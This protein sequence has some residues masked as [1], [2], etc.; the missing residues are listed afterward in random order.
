MHLKL[1]E[2]ERKEIEKTIQGGREA[3][4]LKDGQG[5]N[6][7]L[8]V[9]ESR[10]HWIDGAS[11]GWLKCIGRKERTNCPSMEQMKRV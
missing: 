2:G 3:S 7:K 5:T 9:I 6:V 8:A 1:A 4:D 11:Q 10:G